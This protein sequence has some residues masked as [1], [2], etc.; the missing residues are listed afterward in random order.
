M[1]KPHRQTVRQ[2]DR[3]HTAMMTEL[4]FVKAFSH[5]YSDEEIL[6]ALDRSIRRLNALKPIR[7]KLVRPWWTRLIEAVR[8]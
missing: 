6:R 5:T 3:V 7:A 1:N 2:Y 4:Q 8:P